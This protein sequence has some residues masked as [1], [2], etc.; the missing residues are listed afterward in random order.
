MTSE[1]EPPIIKPAVSPPQNPSHGAAIIFMHGLGDDA[2]GWENIADQFQGGNKLP[3]MQWIFPEAT[4]NRD[5]MQKAWYRQVR[6]L[7]TAPSRPELEE[8]EDEDGM[9]LSMKYIESLI[10]GLTSRGVPP[11]RIVLAG[12]SQGCAMA[13]LTGLTS[14]KYAD[15]LAGLVCLSGYFPLINRMQ[16]LRSEND[17]PSE[18]GHVPVFLVRGQKDFA[19]PRRFL[20]L[21][22]DKFKEFG[23]KDDAVEVHEYEDLAHTANARELRDLCT[24]LEK[25]V[26]PLE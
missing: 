24:W 16:A 26:P 4:E 11:N 7:A 17:L 21:C 13:L 3:Y 12:F 1:R 25:V 22:I 18:V 19:V 20:T 6:L 15:K 2:A 14:R 5:A 23:F 10:D 8:D 9:L